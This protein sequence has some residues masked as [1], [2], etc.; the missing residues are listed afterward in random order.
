M[1]TGYVD[2][3]GTPSPASGG[4]FFTV[5]LLLVQTPRHIGTLVR[6]IRRSL[7]RRAAISELKAAHS[8]PKVIYRLL[9]GLAAVECEIYITVVDKQSIAPQ[10]S[11]AM[12]R[13]AVAN[14]VHRCVE[15]HPRVNLYLDRRYSNRTQQ[16]RLEQTIREAIAQVPMQ[17]VLIE[18]LDSQAVPGLQAV[19]FVAWAFE[20]K[21]ATGDDSAARIVAGR[22]VVE[23][24]LRGT[25]I[26]ALP[27]GR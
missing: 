9:N 2:E 5:A 21:H 8:H 12:Y 7:H 4:Q 26:A 18:Q 19:D 1:P 24:M 20:Q 10:Q 25:K 3:S 13:A 17:V 6:R 15:R 23:E 14:V 27:G 22:V 16:A 11:E